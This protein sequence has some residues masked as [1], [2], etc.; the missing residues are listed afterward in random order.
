MTARIVLILLF[1]FPGMFS[2]RRPDRAVI[3]ADLGQMLLIGF[4]GTEFEAGAP[5][6]IL[7]TLRELNIGGVVLF[8]YDVPSRS[9]P[10]NIENA[11]QV[12]RLTGALQKVSNKQL[13]IAVDAEG[14][15]INRLKTEYGFL[16]IPSAAEMG[17]QKPEDCLAVYTGLAG[18]LADLGI[19]MNLAPVVD[20]DIN[21]EN[22]VIGSLDRSF[23]SDPEAFLPC[24][25][26]FIL[27]HHKKGVLTTL[28]HFPGHGSSAQDSHNGLV[29]VTGTFGQEEL[30]P[31][32]DLIAENLADA[33]MTAHIHNRNIDPDLPATLSPK[34]L[35]GILR[36]QLGFDGVIISD[37][38]QMGAI[39]EYYGFEEAVVMAVSAGCDI[40]AIANN[41]GHYDEEA[42]RK[43]HQAILQAF[44][45]GILSEDR[46]L[47][48]LARISRLKGRLGS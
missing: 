9:Y 34:F 28:K 19:N 37:D 45:D 31:Y 32:R 1:L 33:V 40:I 44:R 43:A 15:R 35:Q 41:S 16:D 2:G 39:T 29:D 30:I 10:R 8:D 7:Q 6:P 48:S 17:K 5:A 20:L 46:I 13:L 3:E 21:P 47:R 23:G 27:A 26:A 4:R 12:R 36:R 25:R 18:Q 24:V 14:G 38:I 42:P 11:A 22:P